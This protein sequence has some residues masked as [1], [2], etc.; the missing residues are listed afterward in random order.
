MRTENYYINYR[1]NPGSL[2]THLSLDYGAV[3]CV[4][5]RYRKSAEKLLAEL[6]AD[7]RI[8]WAQLLDDSVSLATSSYGGPARL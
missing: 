8:Q 2:G 5:R 3:M 7:P 4:A 6:R 1:Y